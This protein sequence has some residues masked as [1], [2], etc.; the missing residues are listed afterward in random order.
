M[1]EVDGDHRAAHPMAWGSMSLSPAGPSISIPG[2]P[3][4][5]PRRRNSSRAGSSVGVR[6]HHQLAAT[7]DRDIAF[8]RISLERSLSS[9]AE[10][11][12][13]VNRAGNRAR[14]GALRCCDRSGGRRGPVPCP[15]SVVEHADAGVGV[16]GQW[17]DPRCRPPR[18]RCR[19]RPGI[20]R[21]G[22]L[23]AS[24]AGGPLPELNSGNTDAQSARKRHDPDD[25][26]PKP[27]GEPGPGLATEIAGV[28]IHDGQVSVDCPPHDEQTTP[29][30]LKFR[31]I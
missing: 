30:M 3:F 2:T 23:G 29:T 1:I 31:S 24:T 12:P 27:G 20:G 17:P 10:T 25:L 8:F 14:H 5:S 22:V 6:G 9:P 7:V 15:E 26:R 21:S 28:A 19:R 16:P 18:R 4:A 13:S 11:A